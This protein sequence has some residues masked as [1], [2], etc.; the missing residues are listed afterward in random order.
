LKIKSIIEA[1]Y[2]EPNHLTLVGDFSFDD[3]NKDDMIE[4]RDVVVKIKIDHEREA[5]EENNATLLDDLKF[6]GGRPLEFA[7]KYGIEKGI[8]VGYMRDRHGWMVFG[9]I[10]GP[11]PHHPWNVSGK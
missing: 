10:K 2:A 5:H 3:R 11:G 9:W 1:K 7:K 4:Y 8:E 6:V